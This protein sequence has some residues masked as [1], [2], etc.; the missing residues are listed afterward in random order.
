MADKLFSRESKK[1][2]LGKEKAIFSDIPFLGKG[3]MRKLKMEKLIS[4]L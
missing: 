4:S 1:R 3:D 2:A